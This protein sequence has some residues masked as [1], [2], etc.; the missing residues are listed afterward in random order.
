MSLRW[1]L[2]SVLA[3]VG[4]FAWLAIG[5]FFPDE[6]R[7]SA[8]WLPE[9]GVRL[10]LDLRGGIHMVISPDLDVALQQE[11]DSIRRD[12]EAIYE[13]EDITAAQAR[14]DGEQVRLLT[15]TT[16]DAAKVDELLD[17]WETVSVSRPTDVE[18]V[19]DLT[20]DSRE[21]V[22]D[23]AMGQALEVLRRRI[24][25]P[26]T[27]IPE[28]VITKQGLERILIQI[29]GLDRVPDI[30]RTT[31]YLEFKIVQDTA[32]TE[33]LLRAKY[34]G[35]LP[36]DTEIGFERDPETK[37]VL[38]AYLMPKQP[39]MTGESLSDARVGFDTRRAGEALV[40]FTWDA[41]GGR[42]F[43]KLTEENLQKPLAIILDGDV[44]S[45]PIIQSRISRQ[46]QITGRFTSKEA[47]DLAIILRAGAL[48][49]PLTIEEE[50][51]IGPALG[52][53]SIGRGL[54]AS[55][56]GLMVIV[57]FMVGYYRMSGGYASVAL[58]ANLLMIGGLMSVFEGTLTVPGIAGL[59]LTVGMA[60]DANV[61]IFERI[62]E[63]L[64]TGRAPRAAIS[65]GF[66]KARWTILDANI[67]TLIT[68]IILFNYGTGP[69]KGFAVTLSVGILTSVFAALVLTR[70]LYELNPGHKPVDELSI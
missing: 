2:G 10:G 65:A 63:E 38:S 18:F 57:L 44:V 56:L 14:V 54:R 9:D 30:F 59:V 12:W 37:R 22:R 17:R 21:R 68:A 26:Q 48:P 46:G 13:E 50:R 35:G 53:D 31:G 32:P 8:W 45:A 42:T 27:G 16:Q 3:L 66:E 64:R 24:D 36:E 34:E 51:T 67:T 41:D 4:L 23:N 40:N 19:L 58:A 49:I 29:P 62:R 69:I 11:L 61:I 55:A 6:M 7:K 43:G 25:D 33:E 1:R 15:S 47:T 39:D 28:S 5:G 70:L 52:A 20:R 60:V